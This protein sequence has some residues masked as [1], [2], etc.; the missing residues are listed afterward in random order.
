MK[1]PPAQELLAKNV[2]FSVDFYE[3]R[4]KFPDE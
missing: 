1:N 4:K 3:K 2:D